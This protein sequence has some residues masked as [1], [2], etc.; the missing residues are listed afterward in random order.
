MML[1]GTKESADNMVQD[2]GGGAASAARTRSERGKQKVMVAA[3]EGM[4]EFVT[5]PDLWAPACRRSPP[6]LRVALR[7]RPQGYD[8]FIVPPPD[9]TRTG[10]RLL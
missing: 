9:Q 1:W 4:G 10:G 2:V 5:L 8:E 6:A 3:P 7:A